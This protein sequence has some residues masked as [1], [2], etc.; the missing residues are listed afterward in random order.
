M[1][2]YIVLQATEESLLASLKSSSEE[3]YQGWMLREVH[4][5]TGAA[6][7]FGKPKRY[8]FDMARVLPWWNRFKELNGEEDAA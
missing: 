2:E 5:D 6:E 1:I 3:K 4:R 8:P 7:K